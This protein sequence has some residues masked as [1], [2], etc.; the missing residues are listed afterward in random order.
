VDAYNP[1]GEIVTQRKIMIVKELIEYLK[2]LD[3]NTPVLIVDPV[4]RAHNLDLDELFIGK[5]KEIYDEWR[6]H[7]EGRKVLEIMG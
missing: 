7:P 1:K 2:T 3:E 5:R 4:N 6:E